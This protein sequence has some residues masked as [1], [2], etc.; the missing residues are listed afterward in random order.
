M[1]NIDTLRELGQIN[2]TSMIGGGA[3][4]DVLCQMFSDICGLDIDVPQPTEFA[5]RGAA[6]AA[7]L[8][9]GRFQSPAD[10]GRK[11]VRIRTTYHPDHE[12]RGKYMSRYKLF[13]RS[14][15][16]MRALWDEMSE[17]AGGSG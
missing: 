14:V 8:G 2:S 5:A 3:R 9:V 17:L 7:G 13:T 6:L 1:Q 11:A 16:N 4:S 10:L 12:R 15:E